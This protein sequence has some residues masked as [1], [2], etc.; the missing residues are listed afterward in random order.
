[1]AQISGRITTALTQVIQKRIY[2]TMRIPALAAAAVLVFGLAACGNNTTT[3]GTTPA[4]A[5]ATTTQAAPTEAATTTTA[6]AES[7]GGKETPEAAAETVMHAFGNGDGKA[8]CAV[9]ASQGRPLEKTAGAVDQCATTIQGM[10]DQMKDSLP[11]FKTGTV[12]GATINGDTA[13]FENATVKPEMAK[14]MMTSFKAQKISGKW[15]ITQ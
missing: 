8:A 13:S 14:S 6:P 4:P 5:P 9:M 15:Y 3:P 10:M 11:E 12:T 7:L 2:P 1:M